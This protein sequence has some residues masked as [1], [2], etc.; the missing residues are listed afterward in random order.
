[1]WIGRSG[2]WGRNGRDKQSRAQSRESG[3]ENVQG[4]ES[5]VQSRK[6]PGSRVQG[7][8]QRQK[9]IRLPLLALD[10]GLWTLDH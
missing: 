7:P 2:F 9:A 8:E 3:A 6:R 1:M 4:P 10:S 5:R